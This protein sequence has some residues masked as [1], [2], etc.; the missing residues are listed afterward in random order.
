MSTSKPT[1]KSSTLLAATIAGLGTALG[2]APVDLLGAEKAA[3]GEHAPKK[4]SVRKGV[5]AVQFKDHGTSTNTLKST[6][7][8]QTQLKQTQ[9][10]YTS[11]TGSGTGK[12]TDAASPKSTAL[13]G[14]PA[15]D[16]SPKGKSLNTTGSST[17]TR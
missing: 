9:L 12:V 7:L 16:E 4:S 15:D 6:Q 1:N 3:S 13:E 5:P 14:R 8:K 11:G 2:V 10:K 17:S